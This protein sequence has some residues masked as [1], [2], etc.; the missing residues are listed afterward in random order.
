MVIVLLIVSGVFLL[1]K[2]GNKKQRDFD[3][4]QDNTSHNRRFEMTVNESYITTDNTYVDYDELYATPMEG[5]RRGISHYSNME[6]SYYDI[7]N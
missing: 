3:L 4:T 2:K 1:R 7:P 6:D 5:Q